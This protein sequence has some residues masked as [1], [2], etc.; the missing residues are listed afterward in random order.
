MRKPILLI[1]ILSFLFF[2]NACE[3]D[4]GDTTRPGIL[5]GAP[6]DGDTLFVGQDIHFEADFMDETELKS[7]KID[8]HNNFDGHNHKSTSDE[9]EPWLFQQSWNFEAGKKNAHIHHHEVVVPELVNGKD[10]ATGPYHFM[11]YCTDAAGNESWTVV[12]VVVAHPTD[13]Q[14]PVFSGVSAPIIGQTF[15]TGQPISISATVSDNRQLAGLF[16]A[17]LPEGA[18]QAEMTPAGCFAVMLHTHEAVHEKDS[19]TFTASITVGQTNDNNDPSKLITWIPGNYIIMMK[20]IDESG[21]VGF[22]TSYPIVIQ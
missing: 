11:V 22:S 18:T 17:L 3:K 1:S 4:G 20:S 8:I 12:G 10:I 21:N 13:K 19:Y 7:Y 6:T 5:I 14:P 9:Y 15:S 16:V 2:L